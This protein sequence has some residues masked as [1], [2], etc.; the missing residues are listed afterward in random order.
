MRVTLGEA[1]PEK[2]E[3]LIREGLKSISKKSCELPTGFFSSGIRGEEK[4]LWLIH[5]AI[6]FL[7]I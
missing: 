3:D 7:H 5:Y 4:P 1:L 6:S 2:T